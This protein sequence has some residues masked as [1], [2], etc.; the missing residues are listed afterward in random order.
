[1]HLCGERNHIG[2][3]GSNLGGISLYF[4]DYRRVDSTG[5]HVAGALAYK[6]LADTT[7]VENAS[8]TEAG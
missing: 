6:Y 3:Q 8:G 5:H 2:R 1:M 7:F 4:Y